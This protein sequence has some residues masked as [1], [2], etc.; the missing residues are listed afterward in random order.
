MKILI[1][2]PHMDD[3]ILS[4]TDHIRSWQQHHEVTV[5]T[6]FNRYIKSNSESASTYMYLSG[7]NSVTTLQRE[8]DKEDLNAF[9]ELQC[10]NVY[11][12]L[13]D[14]AF[15][16]NDNNILYPTTASIFNNEISDG[17]NALNQLKKM[18]IQYQNYDTI[19]APLAIGNHVDHRITHK[20]AKSVFSKKQLAYYVDYPY[21]LTHR[22]RI[23]W[24]SNIKPHT[25]MKFSK[26]KCDIVNCYISQVPQLFKQPIPSYEEII[27][28]EN[29]A[30]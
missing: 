23:W 9:N 18:F 15:R 25:K 20:A 12:Q 6:I 8:R 24:L 10:R 28:Y 16:K 13:T 4:C 7:F 3:A 19:V 17:D 30:I 14:A 26:K 22:P 1:L 11:G 21:A 29:A 27:F 5:F 2:S